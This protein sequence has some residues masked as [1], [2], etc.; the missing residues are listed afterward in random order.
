MYYNAKIYLPDSFK[1]PWHISK[2]FSTWT[3]ACEQTLFY[4]ISR[5]MRFLLVLQK[6]IVNKECGKVGHDK[7]SGHGKRI[8]F[9]SYEN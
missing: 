3:W 8:N 9:N 6:L 7:I 1:N 5:A 4:F 2:I